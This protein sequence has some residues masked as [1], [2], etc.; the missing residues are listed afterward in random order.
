MALE[1]KHEKNQNV[2]DA[3]AQ[4][5]TRDHTRKIFQHPFLY[6]AADTSDVM[7]AT[8]PRREENF[9]WH[10]MGLTNTPHEPRRISGRVP[11]PRSACRRSS[12]WRRCRSSWSA[13]PKREAEDDKPE[14]PPSRIFPRYHQSRMVRKVADDITAHFAAKGDIGRKYLA[15]HS[16]GSGK[17]LSICW[18]ADRLHSLFKPGTNEKLVDIM[19]I[20]TDRK[21]LDTNIREDIENFTHLKDV[22]GIARKADDLP[23]FL[24]ERKPIIVTTQQKFAWVLEEIESNPALKNLRVAFLIDEAHRSQEGQM[25][26][27]I[28]LP[29][30]KADEPDADDA[31][32]R[33]GGT[34]RQGHPRARPQ[35]VVRRVHR[36]AR[37]GHGDAVRRAVRHLHRGRGHRRRLHRGRGGE[38]H[39]LQDALQPALPFR[40]ASRTRRKSSIPRASCPRRCMNVAFQD[41]GLIQYKAEVMLRIFEEEREAAHRRPRQSDDRH[42]LARGRAALFQHHQGKAQRARRGLQSALRLLGF[43]ASGNQRGNQRARRQRA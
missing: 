36:H 26:A 41:D 35:S 10:N 12:C 37:A 24:K 18:L 30:R 7:A 39:L 31:G 2:H 14:R 22:V 28:R 21:S 8:D 25:G 34:D 40:S 19:F 27:A 17:T 38:H 29:F 13:C 23:R 9:R 16:A 3:V 5:A 20:L 15:N 11:L 1:L 6:L 42:Q 43:R 4:F 32:A 33:P